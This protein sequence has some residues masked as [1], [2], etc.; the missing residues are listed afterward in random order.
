MVSPSFILVFSMRGKNREGGG[1]YMTL[2]LKSAIG[3]LYT[4]KQAC[5][6][7][8]LRLFQISLGITFFNELFDQK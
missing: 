4:L 3:L 5:L 6:S 7:L 1:I 2:G 8:L